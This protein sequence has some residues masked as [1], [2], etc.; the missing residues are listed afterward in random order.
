MKRR[1]QLLGKVIHW[2][3]VAEQGSGI[4]L[5]VDFTSLLSLG[6]LMV[7]SRTGI[8]VRAIAGVSAPM[9]VEAV[10]RAQRATHM[11]LDQLAISL[12]HPRGQVHTNG[13][14]AAKSSGAHSGSIHPADGHGKSDDIAMFHSQAAA[15]CDSLRLPDRLWQRG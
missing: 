13:D 1:E 8:Q 9:L 14:L 5:L 2:V 4:L 3:Q 12:A 11:T 6:E 10:R 15:A 7:P